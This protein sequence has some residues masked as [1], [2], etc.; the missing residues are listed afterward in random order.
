MAVIIIISI[1]CFLCERSSITK[2]CS[3]QQQGGRLDLLFL[4]FQLLLFFFLLNQTKDLFHFLLGCFAWTLFSWFAPE[5]PGAGR[6]CLFHLFVGSPPPPPSPRLPKV[7]LLLLLFGEG[8]RDG[9]EACL[10]QERKERKKRRVRLRAGLKKAGITLRD[11]W[12]ECQVWPHILLRVGGC[13]GGIDR[14]RAR[15]RTVG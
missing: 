1:L 6:N 2:W 4:L 15:L 3:L 9:F 8:K 5:K 13:V 11:C 12:V 10:G 14:F 7:L